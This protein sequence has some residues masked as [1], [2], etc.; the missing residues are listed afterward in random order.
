MPLVAQPGSAAAQAQAA[1]LP[2]QL[3]SKNT[4]VSIFGWHPK[5]PNLGGVTAAKQFVSGIAGLPELATGLLVG[6]TETWSNFTKGTLGALG[7]VAATA[8]KPLGIPGTEY[9]IA[10]QVVEP[11]FGSMG[12][13]AEDL[14]QQSRREG[15][16]AAFTNQALTVAALATPIAGALGKA[17][18]AAED[19][20]AVSARAAAA[21][22]GTASGEAAAQAAA[23]QAARAAQLAGQAGLARKFAHPFGTI[24]RAGADITAAAREARF[25]ATSVT[26]AAA[27]A[28]HE[29]VAQQQAAALAEEA[30]QSIVDALKA[31][32]APE[33]GAAAA[34]TRSTL[35]DAAAAAARHVEANPEQPIITNRDLLA[36]HEGPTM[37]FYRGEPAGV[38]GAA[39][40]TNFTSNAKYAKNFAGEGGTVYRVELPLDET[41]TPM[42][43]RPAP[44]GHVGWDLSQHADWADAAVPVEEAAAKAAEL[45]RT[46]GAE[47]NP[48]PQAAAAEAAQSI[49]EATGANKPRQSYEAA[50]QAKRL[51]TP[52]PAWAKRLTAALPDSVNRVLTYANRPID[53][54]RLHAVARD[55][56]RYVELAQRAARQSPGVVAARGAALEIMQAVPELGR[57]SLSNMIGEEIAARLDGTA[58]AEAAIKATGNPNTQLVDAL[59]RVAKRNYTGIPDDVW[60][61]LS[62]EQRVAVE[63]H[64]NDAVGAHRAASVERLNTLLSSTR[65]AQGLEQAL[66]QDSA[67]VMTPSQVKMYRKAMND[68]RRAA[69]LKARVP[70]EISAMQA[71]AERAGLGSEKAAAEAT[72][73]RALVGNALRA[74]E[75]LHD[76]VPLGVAAI[77]TTVGDIMRGIVEDGG[78][79]YDVGLGRA[80][81]AQTTGF[82]VGIA[83]QF[84]VPLEEFAQRG[85]QMIRDA[86]ENPRD[87]DGNPYGQGVWHGSDAR[88]GG[89]VHVGDDGRQY[90]AVDIS[91]GTWRN[92][93]LDQ[94]QASILGE[95]YHQQAIWDVARGEEIYLSQQPEVQNLNAHY[96]ND[97]LNPNSEMSRV[98]RQLQAATEGAPG[99]TGDDVVKEMRVMQTWDY[100][101][102]RSNPEYTPGT[103]FEKAAVTFGKGEPH[104]ADWLTQTVLGLGTGEATNLALQKLSPR[105]VSD[106]LAWYYD[107]HDYVESTWRGKEIRLLNGEMRDAAEVFYD[108]LAVTSVMASPTQ[109]LGRALS[110]VANMEEFMSSRAGAIKA[111]KSLMKRLEETP[112]DVVYVADVGR[113]TE[114]IV[115]RGGGTPLARRFMTPEVR[116]LT[117]G[118]SMTNSPKYNVFD[119]ITGKLKLG[120]ATNAEIGKLP[121]WWTGTPKSI[122]TANMPRESVVQMFDTL[123]ITGPAAD[124][125]REWASTHADIVAYRDTIAALREANKGAGIKSVAAEMLDG[126]EYKTFADLE[127]AYKASKAAEADHLADPAVARAF[128]Q[129]L[130]EYHGS[131]A[132]AKLRSFRDNLANPHESLGVTL[133]SVMAQMYGFASTDWAGSGSY[134]A[135]ANEVREAAQML[136]KR[137]GYDVKPHEVQ[138]LLWVYTK[139]E[140]G[141]QDWGRLLQH[142][143]IGQDAID[144]FE[145]RA[146]AG[147]PVNAR[148]FDPLGDYYAEELGYSKDALDI[149]Q[150]RAYLAKKARLKTATAEDLANLEALKNADLGIRESTVEVATPRADISQRPAPGTGTF[151]ARLEL[152]DNAGVVSRK[153]GQFSNYIATRREIQAALE[154]GNY[155]EARK[156]LT[157]YTLRLQ[158]SVQGDAGGS[159]Q[160]V[161]EATRADEASSAY[162]A[163]RRLAKAK[164]VPA[165]NQWRSNFIS[166]LAARYNRQFGLPAPT[167]IDL[168]QQVLPARTAEVAAAVQDLIERRARG[169]ITPAEE[170]ASE[171]SYRALQQAIDQQY[172]YMTKTLGVN[173]EY[174][175]PDR[176][177]GIGTLGDAPQP[178]QVSAAHAALVDDVRTNNRLK[179]RSTALAGDGP[180]EFMGEMAPDGIMYNDKLRA[181]HDFFGHTQAANDFSRHGENIAQRLHL[182]MFPEEAKAALITEFRAQTAYLIDRKTFLADQLR[183]LL[184]DAMRQPDYMVR[185]SVEELHQRWMGQIRGATATAAD[186]TGRLTM[187]L[188]HDAAMDTLLHENGHLLRQLLPSEDMALVERQYPHITDAE[189]TPV[190]RAAEEAF[191]SDMLLYVRKAVRSGDLTGPLSDVFRRVAATFEEQHAAWIDS[192]TG[193]STTPEI[194]SFWDRMFNPEIISPNT[195]E[196]PIS[197][198]RVVPGGVETKRFR[199]ESDAQF[200]QRARQ[201]GEARQAVETA[202]LRASQA[203]QRA[204]LADR[205]HQ[206]MLAAV[207]GPTEYGARAQRLEA[208]A[209]A[210]LAKLGAELEEP[211][212]QQVPAAWQPLWEAFSA[213]HRE[214]KLDETGQL[215][216][217]LE[218]IPKNFTE[219]LRFAA[220][221]GFEPTHV[222][223]MTWEQA[224]RLM[225]NH[226]QL[227]AQAEEVSSLRK[228][229]V[230]A[231]SR[232]GLADRSLEALGAGAVAATKEVYTNELV[233]FIET[234]YA[235]PLTHGAAIPEGWTAWDSQRQYIL[236]GRRP[237]GAV[238]APSATM[239]VPDSVAKAITSMSNRY[240]HWLFHAVTR[241]TSPWRTF[242]LTLSPKWYVNNF[243]GNTLLATAEGVRLSDW[244]TAFNQWKTGATPTELIGNSFIQSL[245]EHGQLIGNRPVRE[246]LRS[247][248]GWRG[249][250][251]EVKHRLTRVNTVWDEI[252][253]AAVFEK[254]LRT[255]GSRE[256][257]LTRAYKAMVDYGDL[258]PF[259]RATVRS[260]IP[261]Y[262]WQKGMLKLVLRFP[263]DHP[264]ASAV[265]LQLGN[266]HMETL[267]DT[268]GGPIPDA[269]MG[270]TRIAGHNVN[271][272]ALNPFQDATQLLTPQGIAQSINP[273]IS[274]MLQ[275]AYNAPKPGTGRPALSATGSRTQQVDYAQALAGQ[276]AGLPQARLVDQLS[277]G[278]DVYGQHHTAAGSIGSFLGVPKTYS[279]AD[280]A[281]IANRV[282]KATGN[283]PPAVTAAVTGSM[284]PKVRP[285]VP[286]KLKA[287][288]AAALPR[289]RKPRKKR[290]KKGAHFT[291]SQAVRR[292]HHKAQ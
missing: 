228:P 281:T 51:S 20:A 181:V 243:V 16:I 277:T 73:A 273:Y 271:T 187:R 163:E 70:E 108:L 232:A 220:E 64:I 148:A 77:E 126:S 139:L 50:Q 142:H 63:T 68:L 52:A 53:S 231:L 224:Q 44:A 107:S 274:M 15:P 184:P 4:G 195:Y 292:S 265:L 252:S 42:V 247:D 59:R 215:A 10:D 27:A 183:D 270:I 176:E 290:L 48:R 91:M 199:W 122:S 253:R 93:P 117:E 110:G 282:M 280:V 87:M 288:H 192:L 128:D 157:S 249:A 135:K 226:I 121:E 26:E 216:A 264:L 248:E 133:D 123:G 39:T 109:N 278:N 146:L 100:A 275:D 254:T 214:A 120:E 159:F 285:T 188:F 45:P 191:V 23:T 58:L 111:V 284:I 103:I 49:E 230:G 156:L 276:L 14:L 81:E 34:T 43:G 134:A 116:A 152:P 223:D 8:T 240:D 173:V 258:S 66:L 124:A 33:T 143:D 272:R 227:G 174:V 268:L 28:P 259:E 13:H 233:K 211:S 267:Q 19:A 204:T 206:E 99:I 62:D 153:E 88:L 239:I 69:K 158:R 18:G 136:S 255:T 12:V 257:A 208:R 115:E 169:E 145:Q 149:R 9:N 209:Q 96:V 86:V 266:A 40:G 193:R 37:T 2:P 80:A 112:N 160:V 180:N 171:A 71:A 238:V 1:S 172:E 287:S 289:I 11:A 5:M 190:R 203:T 36:G 95:A 61:A 90:V 213:L 269:Y 56:A 291:L 166:P 178:E 201:Y 185:G 245:D 76:G 113:E 74:A 234:Y 38:E 89:W 217:A 186:D 57:A 21:A 30:H 32:V 164:K 144:A 196:D 212:T 162:A 198:Q 237:S 197:L 127:R 119:I 138:A 182:Q 17:A 94:V 101:M 263:N 177:Y 154:A 79:T 189:L 151:E 168:N 98:S 83:E 236:S 137:F 155:D 161:G 140:T 22:E 46:L 244:R 118:T 179:V 104:R 114:R 25:P 84:D 78:I 131:N 105:V 130:T 150:Q 147:E 202:R 85:E 175:A 102:S 242:L 261:F 6:D 60:A 210:T 241:V 54:F 207:A 3:K 262:A 283:T 260:V 218:D 72:K 97:I 225:F 47:A 35:E 65:G 29:V 221:M 194:G 106:A 222:P 129:A 41:G 165:P 170:A 219:T 246:V 24:A 200:T 7:S 251:A 67:P 132:L 167:A 235:Q 229:R 205:A 92:T 256:A 31:S 55:M 82:T 286:Q 75:T 141:R 250:V 125:Y 279:P